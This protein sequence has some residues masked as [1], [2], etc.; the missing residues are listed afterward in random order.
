M[1]GFTRRRLARVEAQ[2]DA[3]CA[4][5]RAERVSRMHARN[6]AVAEHAIVQR[7]EDERCELRGGEHVRVERTEDEE[8]LALRRLNDSHL[9]CPPEP[10]EVARARRAW[11]SAREPTAAEAFRWSYCRA[12]DVRAGVKEPLP[13]R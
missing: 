12:S 2:R 5:D 4:P 8:A 7:W 6:A 1:A 11:E 10:P 9:V 13:A 3:G